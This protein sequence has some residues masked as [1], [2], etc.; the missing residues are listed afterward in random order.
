MLREVP[1]GP[2]MEAL[3][4]GC[5]T[6]LVTLELQPRVRTITGLDGSAGMLARLAEKARARGLAN[7]RWLQHDLADAAPLPGRYD[8]VA[9]S[10]TLHH[11]ADA[12]GLL[13]RIHAALRPGGWLAIA[14]L[15]PDGGEFHEDPA[16]VH[17]PGFERRELQAWAETAGLGGVRFAEAARTVKPRPGGPREFSV[18]LLVARRP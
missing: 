18:F 3:D 14:D 12:P 1:V 5:G 7:V 16:G 11:V 9:S 17:H 2:E 8:L 13:R 10:L 4:L 15:E 6:G